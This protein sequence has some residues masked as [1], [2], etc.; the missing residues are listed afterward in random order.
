MWPERRTDTVVLDVLQMRLEPSTRGHE[1]WLAATIR[2][3]LVEAVIIV[4]CVRWYLRFPLSA[5]NV[6]RSIA[7]HGLSVDHTIIWRPMHRPLRHSDS[8]A[9]QRH[10]FRCILCLEGIPFGQNTHAAR[11]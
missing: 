4:T 1:E 5:R 3:A 6:A 2:Q 9:D 11:L 8:S 10:G 7:E